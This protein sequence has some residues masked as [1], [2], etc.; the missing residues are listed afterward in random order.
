MLRVNLS[1]SRGQEIMNLEKSNT[2]EQD[3]PQ[4]TMPSFRASEP[5]PPGKPRS[6]GWLWLLILVLVGVAV[7][8]FRSHASS[9]KAASDSAQSPGGMPGRG[10]GTIPVVGAI[11]RKGNIGVYDTGLGSVTPIYIGDR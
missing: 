7:Y 9:A 1:N 5:P 3:A 10:P 8:Y 4:A 2:V 11:V 6:Y